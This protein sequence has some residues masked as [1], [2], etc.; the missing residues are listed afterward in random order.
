VANAL[1]NWSCCATSKKKLIRL[2]PICFPKSDM[3][4]GIKFFDAVK[5]Y[6][7]NIYNFII[8]KVISFIAVSRAGQ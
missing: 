5:N 7:L 3:R 4:Y 6:L 2:K 8:F 1:P